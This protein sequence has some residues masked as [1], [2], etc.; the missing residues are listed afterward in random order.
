LTTYYL[1]PATEALGE[2]I[3]HA[4]AVLIVACPCAMGLATP[5]AIMV[6]AG[7]G[8]KR[9]ILVKDGAALEAARRITTVVFDKTG[10]LTQGKPVVTDVVPVGE[11]DIAFLIHIAASLESA[12]E[13]PLAQAVMTE[14]ESRKIQISDVAD[15]VAVPGEGIEGT[16]DGQPSLL[17]KPEWV[18]RIV[19]EQ[20]LAP[21]VD[22]FRAQAKTVISVAQSGRLLGFIAVQDKPKVDA[23]KAVKKLGGMN[24]EVALLTGDHRATAEAIARELG[25]KQVYA[26][27]SPTGKA[28]KIKELQGQGEKVAFVGDGLNDAPA[29]AQ[30]DL[31]L[32]MGTGTDVAMA[33]GQMV[34]MGGSPSKV[35]EAIRL[36]RLTFSAIKQNLFWAF[37]YNIIGIP[38][39]AFGVL[40]PMLAGLAMAFSSVSVLTNSLRIAK[41]MG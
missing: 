36:A 41:R 10:T 26:E 8:A 22:E 38:L 30:S 29:L 39:A 23:A 1:L 33:A 2:A 5:A 35:P 40:N 20:S 32:A 34:L 14:A 12:S 19:G 17:G 37:V 11:T 31:G 28:D 16:I 9:G 4:V 3:R 25:I 6:G 21:G 7:A 15:F 13:H 24:L 18:S 27:V